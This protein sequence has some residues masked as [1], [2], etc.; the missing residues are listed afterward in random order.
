M[1]S[2]YMP[3][4]WAAFMPKSI[5][6]VEINLNPSGFLQSPAAA[7]AI[8]YVNRRMCSIHCHKVWIQSMSICKS[9]QGQ[10]CPCKSFS[11]A[12]Q[13]FAC[14]QCTATLGLHAALPCSDNSP[15]TSCMHCLFPST[16]KA[17]LCQQETAEQDLGLGACVRV[18]AYVQVIKLSDA[19]QALPRSLT[20]FCHGVPKAFREVGQKMQPRAE[21]DTPSE[22]SPSTLNGQEEVETDANP[23]PSG[24]G[25]IKSDPPAGQIQGILLSGLCVSMLMSQ[26]WQHF[27]LSTRV[28]MRL[29]VEEN[30]DARPQTHW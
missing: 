25:H 29:F 23:S 14:Q 11:H 15:N 28:G 6:F 30:N 2:C 21:I 13:R 12:S 3:F 16:I 24:V 27:L 7:R 10:A 22:A 5:D 19:V 20:C 17:R 26:A 9:T 8:F 18:S 1:L 4:E